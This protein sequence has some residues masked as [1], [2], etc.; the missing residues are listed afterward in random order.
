MDSWGR[1]Q[2]EALTIVGKL[3]DMGVRISDLVV[4]SRAVKPGD[5]FVAYPGTH[6][7]GRLFIPQAIANGA[8]AV[9]WER[10]DFTWCDDWQ[11]ANSAVT[12]LQSLAGSIAHMAYGKPSES[13][14]VIG[15]TG[16]NG[17]TSCSQWLARALDLLDAKSAVV[18]TLGSGFPDALDKSV[19]NTTP[20]AITLHREL[21]RFV[22]AGA[23]AVVM[24][25]SSIGLAQGRLNGIGFDVALFTNLTR[26]HLDYHGNMESYAAAKARLFDWPGLKHA[27]LNLD[28]AFGRKI[29]ATLGG[30]VNRIGFCLERENE[31]ALS[32]VVDTLLVARNISVGP[33]GVEFDIAGD[34]AVGSAHVRNSAL[35]RFNVSNLL[36]VAAALFASGHA[37]S[38]IATVLPQLPP[39]SGRLERIEPD[40]FG[41]HPL[42]VV[43]YAHTP[44][45]LEQVL[46]TL[47]DVAN[48]SGGKLVCVF[49]CG[50]DRDRGKRSLMGA[51][52]TRFADKVIVTSDNPRTEDPRV[53]I[54]DI[55]AGCSGKPATEIERGAAI[56]RA[57]RNANPNDVVL[58]AG[59]GHEDSQ[60]IGGGKIPFSDIA[61]ARKVLVT[62][63][64]HGDQA[65]P[66]Q[67]A[68]LNMN[69]AAQAAGGRFVGVEA[70]IYRVVTNSRAIRAG[71]LFVALRGERFDG[72][73]FVTQAAEG[74]AVAAMVDARAEQENEF[75]SVPR[76]IVDDT[77]AGLGRLAA[78]WRARFSI[79]VLAVLGSN[80]KTTVKEMLASIMR[81][82]VGEAGLLA[83]TGNFNNEIGLPLTLLGLG[84]HHRCAV[85][86]MGMNHP[87]EIARLAAI[88]RPTLAVISNAQREHQEFLHTVE[89]AARAN[90]EVFAR[91][92][93]DAVAVLNADDACI[94]IWRALNRSR[95]VVTFA[96]DQPADVRGLC[97]L[98]PFG[99]D[100][101]IVTPDGIV[102]ARLQFA[103]LHN[104]RNAL[105]AA[106]AAW[107]SGV[108]LDAIGAGLTAVAPV[109]GRL[110]KKMSAAGAIVIDDS[111]NANPDSVRA[112]IDVLAKFPAPTVMVLGDMGEVGGQG[113][114][115]HREI[116]A[117]ARAANIGKLFCIGAL[118]QHAVQAFGAA[119]MHAG[120]LDDLVFMVRNN[121]AP[122]AT[123]LVKG[124]RSMKMERV[125][126]A[127]T[128]DDA[129][130]GH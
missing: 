83:T 118:T 29:A 117:Y 15:V 95:R 82:H 21:A 119:G 67:G 108:A 5:V 94:G 31:A 9:L 7:D 42:V 84:T 44:D 52:A 24:E 71:D 103:G 14:W 28:D 30:K 92:P 25:V 65:I 36:G 104:A 96:L 63:A 73:A 10:A 74:G 2:Q 111:Y 8:T 81:R 106:A 85:I 75:G 13:L 123:I 58:I 39:V 62:D 69:D 129:G 49:G 126:S 101:E 19:P 70:Q 87:G 16:T 76:I 110:Q 35:G 98:Q 32:T 79:P 59:K 78:A 112:A 61:V 1:D 86:E 100:L 115:F 4:D 124:S 23:K 41:T 17:K 20:E 105:A 64:L 45:A 72:H 60:E 120:S 33:A 113:P 121:D 77:L 53:I 12:S 93:P 127:L 97:D 99:A 122:G 34:A 89:D 54:A 130:G 50:G 56:I 109:T 3:K 6:Q 47:R 48:G 68:M 114:E 46:V 51:I 18:G 26:D 88:A 38:R 37:L 90:G 116:G 57:I 55:L 91:M 107:A 125:V 128:R 102:H 43:D 11:V 66:G 80:G 40:E 22:R 27:V